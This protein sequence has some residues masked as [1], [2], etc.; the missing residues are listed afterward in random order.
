M[1][2]MLYSGKWVRVDFYLRNCTFEFWIWFIYILKYV[3]AFFF[4]LWIYLYY[5]CLSSLYGDLYHNMNL[6]SSEVLGLPDV[7]YAVSPFCVW[8]LVRILHLPSSFFIH[9]LNCQ[10]YFHHLWFVLMCPPFL[11]L[12]LKVILASQT[13]KC[14]SQTSHVT[15]ESHEFGLMFLPDLR[16]WKFPGKPLTNRA[17]IQILYGSCHSKQA[18]RQMGCHGSQYVQ[19]TIRSKV[20]C[21]FQCC[22]WCLLCVLI[23]LYSILNWIWVR[24]NSFT[25]DST[26]HKTVL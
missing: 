23:K 15:C 26:F 12:D 1:K 3:V 25:H 9:F 19:E 13:E 20:K 6:L 2:A 18:D 22:S 5:V 10:R 16:T 24:C 14:T 11:L 21:I 4:C 7:W 8:T 17:L